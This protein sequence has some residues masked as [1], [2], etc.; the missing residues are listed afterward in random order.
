MNRKILVPFLVLTLLV[1]VTVPVLAQGTGV[2]RQPLAPAAKNPNPSGN[3]APNDVLWF[4]DVGSSGNAFASQFFPDFA[5]GGFSADDFVNADSWSITNIFVPGFYYLCGLTS[6]DSLTW[7]IYP[8]D[9]GVPAGTPLVTGGEFWTFTTTPAGA[10]LTFSNADADVALDV[11]AATGSAITLPAGHWWIVFYPTMSFTTCSQW[12]W[13]TADT[14]N[15]YYGEFVDP[16][17][18]FASCPTWCTHPAGNYDLAFTLEGTTGPVLPT[19]HVQYLH[20]VNGINKLTAAVKVFDDSGFAVGDAAVSISLV[21][22]TE[23]LDTKLTG[24][25]GWAFFRKPAMSGAWTFCVTD[26]VK[27]GFTYDPSGNIKTCESTIFP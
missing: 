15:G 27:A 18:L 19:L 21:G 11:V 2:A 16:W 10:G 22:P 14:T 17:G 4:Q 6:A 5:A 8:D 24:T 3:Q 1:M 25:Y 7:Y 13:M 26:I 9:G 12:F 20:I 23:F